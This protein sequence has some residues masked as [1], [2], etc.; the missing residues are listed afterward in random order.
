M[1]T[2]DDYKQIALTYLQEAC[3]R[4]K[5]AD[6]IIRLLF[7]PSLPSKMDIPQFSEYH[8]SENTI[9]MSE[10]WLESLIPQNGVTML[11][12]DV[13][14]KSRIAYQKIY[15]R[16]E[17]ED[18]EDAIAFA[19]AL[20]G[21]K[22]LS[23]PGLDVLPGITS[24]GNRVC[25]ILKEEFGLDAEIVELLRKFEDGT[26]GY[27]LQLTKEAEKKHLEEY[28]PAPVSSIREITAE[29]K[30]TKDDPFDN[31]DDAFVY[32][33]RLETAAYGNDQLLQKIADADYFYDLVHHQFRYPF[34]S[35][36][37]ANYKN[38]YPKNCF[39]VN[40]NAPKAN[41]NFHF[42][43][44]PNLYGRKFLYR[45]Q[46]EDYAPKPC[47]PNLF[48]DPDKNYFLDDIIWSQ[49]MEL[50]LMTHPL[51]KL[52]EDGV[53]LI[54]DK[55]CFL[56][57]LG[58]LAQH[59]YHKT[60]FLDFTSNQD[61]A[62]FFAVTAYDG[63]TDTYHAIAPADKLGV[64]YL[65][66]LQYPSP[67]FPHIEGYH[68]SVIGKQVFMRSGAQHGFLL[69]M[70]KGLDLKTLPEVHAVY[71]RHNMPISDRV[72]RQSND[73]KDYFAMDLLEKVWKDEYRQ[74]MKDGIVSADTV[75]LNVSLNPGETFD[76]IC[77]KLADKGVTV[78]NGYTPH[79]SQSLLDD[80]YQDIK[81]GW[82][83]E[84][85]RDIYFYG[86][87]GMLYKDA[88][89]RLPSDRRYQSAFYKL[90]QS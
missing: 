57:N 17:E 60:R 73:G 55:F 90:Q 38:N 52:L 85:C 27:I 64:I 18:I 51:V 12:Y 74:K 44:K 26:T 88:L 59:Y 11:R 56:M 69:D 22:G 40:Q 9:F 42:T 62:K 30:G 33:D 71:F 1:T 29:H 32:I 54:H 49:E 70:D 75:K 66:E 13:Y 48:R 80:Y 41:G 89:L 20:I 87:D 35:P 2:I 19:I 15:K 16:F 6:G 14:A 79:F 31:I 8:E 47:T 77:K 63:V 10:E 82:W 53:E 72:F 68:L 28:A 24:L 45:G 58:G 61:V 81:N 37:I 7:V 65:Y 23:L 4:L 67:F 43:L 83:E 84:F 34:A 36:Y 25:T 50:L 46:N 78:D 5:I 21:I 86:A 39:I 76:S 3:H